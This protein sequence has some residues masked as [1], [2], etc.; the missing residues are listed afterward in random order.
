VYISC[1]QDDTA[2]IHAGLT[3]SRLRDLGDITLKLGLD[4]DVHLEIGE[5][6]AIVRLLTRQIERY[7]DRE[8]LEYGLEAE[9]DETDMSG[10]EAFAGAPFPTIR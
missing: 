4:T 8:R 7:E 9:L 5:A 3:P 2:Y 1:Q 10:V 6:H